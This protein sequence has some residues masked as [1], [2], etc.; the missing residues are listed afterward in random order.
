MNSMQ[1][2]FDIFGQTVRTLWAHKLRSFLTM[3]GVA[4]GVGS[5]LLLVGLGEGFR[6]GQHEQLSTIGQD[7]LFMFGGA[8]PAVPGQH[9]DRR[10][11]RLTYG[12]FEAARAEGVHLEPE[13]R[14]FVFNADLVAVIRFLDIGTRVAQEA[15]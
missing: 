1:L 15:R 10:P 13:A 6:V 9:T 3:F 4:W 8:V 2:L 7:I 5:L 12:D 11:Y 14:G